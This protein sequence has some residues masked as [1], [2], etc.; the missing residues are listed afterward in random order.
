M[1]VLGYNSLKSLMFISKV[2]SVLVQRYT[3]RKFIGIKINIKRMKGRRIQNV[4][5]D[6]SMEYC[7]QEHDVVVIP[8]WDQP[9]LLFKI[10]TDNRPGSYLDG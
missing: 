7:W 8:E 4:G 9:W 1:V 3:N 5:G 2:Q 10:I 6:C